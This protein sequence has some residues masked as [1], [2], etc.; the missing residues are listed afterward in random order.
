MKQSSLKSMIAKCWILVLNLQ[1]IFKLEWWTMLEPYN[2]YV[3][4]KLS[5]LIEK[6]PFTQIGEYTAYLGPYE[7]WI[8]NQPYS[9]MRFYDMEMGKYRASRLTIKKAMK[10]LEEDKK[11]H[12]SG[13]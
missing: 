7:M 6:H 11:R 1:F 5:Q 4:K 2:R 8:S 10:K 12:E 13:K 3:D 9:T